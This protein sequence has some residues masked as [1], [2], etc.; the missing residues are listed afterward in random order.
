MVVMANGGTGYEEFM[1]LLLSWMMDYPACDTFDL[2]DI[3]TDHVV[4]IL[5]GRG[6][7]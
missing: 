5:R 7:R 2:C 4:E 6:R 3:G 1:T